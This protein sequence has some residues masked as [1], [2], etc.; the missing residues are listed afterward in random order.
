MLLITAL[1]G[2]ALDYSNAIGERAALQDVADASALAAARLGE[3][4]TAE[5]Y[6]K[7]A[8][9]FFM[10]SKACSKLAC[11]P[12]TVVVGP[13]GAVRV[14]NR[15]NVPTY[16]LD[17]IGIGSVPVSVMAEALPP[18][19]FDV[20]V[21]MVLDYSGSMAW[22]D[23]YVAMA[24]AAT[25]F[26]DRSDDR[27]GD[28]MRVG[29][30]PFSEYVLTPL[31]GQ[32]AFDMA[33]GAALTG[34]DIVGCMLNRQSPQ[35]TTVDT[36]NSAVQG[37]LWPVVSYTTGGAGGASSYSDA[38]DIGI[39]A[40]TITFEGKDYTYE[41][42]DVYPSAGAGSTPDFTS[43]VGDDGITYLEVN[44]HGKFAFQWTNGDWPYHSITN[45]HPWSSVP[46]NAFNGYGDSGSWDTP[47]DGSLPADFDEHQLAEALGGSCGS[48][49]DKSIWARPLTD[50]FGKLKTAID[51]M[52]PLGATNIALGL[53]FGWHYLSA[54]E[55]FSEASPSPNTKRAI[56]LLSDG[57]QTVA[58]HGESGAF[59]VDS[60]NQNITRTCTAAKEAGIEIYTIAFGIADQWTRDLIEGCSSGEGF[61][62]EPSVGAEL[63]S[64]FDDIFDK[65][66]PS[67]PRISM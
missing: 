18:T 30:V 60:A 43:R 25:D 56:V 19:E 21:V 64:V 65:I 12:P 61:Y 36:P 37:S 62:F 15:V 52:E 58:A 10:N 2:G 22:D 39:E 55:P 7:V 28:S 29:I 51:R 38:Y 24:A 3:D 4:A 48:Y 33:G 27:K 45:N 8:Q 66:A 44:G 13:N 5:D 67:K 59:N 35:S 32:Y 9:N 50:D 49:A 20:D 53:D 54:N 34:I 31:K 26:I 63:D 23:R 42:Y 41:L 6:K 11:T 47:A 57:T 16:I 14:E 1:A 46:T 17:V 40:G